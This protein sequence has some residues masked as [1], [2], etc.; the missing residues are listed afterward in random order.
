M[1]RNIILNPGARN[2]CVKHK[3]DKNEAES[4]R[5]GIFDDD[6]KARE[7]NPSCTYQ[8]MDGVLKYL[9]AF[10]Q[11][12]QENIVNYTLCTINNSPVMVPIGSGDNCYLA[13]AYP[14]TQLTC[15][16]EL[17]SLYLRNAAYEDSIHLM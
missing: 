12:Y 10:Q 13:F 15:L 9:K 11:T 17:G 7:A 8:I 2:V 6:I 14:E 3:E 4:Y 5:S 1:Q 16:K